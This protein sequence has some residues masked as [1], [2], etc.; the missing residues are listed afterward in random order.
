MD[1]SRTDMKKLVLY[2]DGGSGFAVID[3]QCS[4][5]GVLYTI[6]PSKLL[7]LLLVSSTTRRDLSSTS[8]LLL[9]PVQNARFK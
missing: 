3:K 2:K 4:S 9:L 6:H 8:N 5:R 7:R 1:N